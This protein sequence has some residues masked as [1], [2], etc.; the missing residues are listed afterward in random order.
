MPRFGRTTPGRQLLRSFRVALLIALGLEVS[1]VVLANAL[2]GFGWLERRLSTAPDELSVRLER[3]WTLIP[4]R[5]HLRRIDLRFE[6]RNVVLGLALE[7][8][9]MDIDLAALALHRLQLTELK[10]DRLIL[11]LATKGDEPA[12]TVLY[13][14]ILAAGARADELDTAEDPDDRHWT[15]HLRGI[16]TNVGELWIREHRYVGS[17][18]LRGGFRLV[19]KQRLEVQASQV[20]LRGGE[21]RYGAHETVARAVQGRARA[22]LHEHPLSAHEGWKLFSYLDLDGKLQADVVSLRSAR[23]YW[24]GGTLNRGEG[25]FRAQLAVQRGRILPRS[26]VEYRTQHLLAA[27]RAFA[28]SGD[29]RADVIAN[30]DGRGG[31]LSMTAERLELRTPR[32]LVGVFTKPRLVMTSDTTDI[33]LPWQ[34]SGAT[35]ELPD[36]RTA[37]LAGL[38]SLVNSEQLRLLSGRATARARAGIDASGRLAGKGELRLQ[39]AE[40]VLAKRVEVDATGRLAIAFEQPRADRVSGDV[41]KLELVLDHVHVRTPDGSTRGGWLRV[42]SRTLQYKNGV[43]MRFDAGLRAGFPDAEPVLAALG[44][45]PSGLGRVATALLDLDDLSVVGRVRYAP[46]TMTVDVTRATTDALTARGRWQ[47]RQGKERGAFLLE[48]QIID[49]GLRVRDGETEIEWRVDEPW[50]EDALRE[51][52]RSGSGS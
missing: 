33:A 8:A 14:P 44:I 29:A 7:R 22:T 21:L 42:D 35:F 17:G 28:L 51:L 37:D 47:R 10:G 18:L 38:S 5:V 9:R 2:L 43:P 49:A 1:Y 12:R 48:T 6:D 13:P 4:G 16:D 3:P 46:A 39:G 11:R 23:G 25:S 41:T 34:L 27:T 40:L 36:V 19:P 31:T 52:T 30:A 15:L 26:F 20:E 50:L 45:R 24:N 32:H